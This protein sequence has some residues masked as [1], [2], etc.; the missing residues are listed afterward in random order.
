MGVNAGENTSYAKT[1]RQEKENGFNRPLTPR[2]TAEQMVDIVEVMKNTD[3]KTGCFK[4]EVD[5]VGCNPLAY[6]SYQ[7]SSQDKKDYM[8]RELRRWIENRCW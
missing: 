5:T 1:M 8:V 4:S 2:E 6:G 7:I 3:V